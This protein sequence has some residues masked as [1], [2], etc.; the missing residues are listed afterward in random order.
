MYKNIIREI[1]AEV[2]NGKK[3]GKNSHPRIIDYVNAI[4]KYEDKNF[5]RK[6]TP[7]EVHKCQESIRR[8]VQHA[9][10]KLKEEG[11]LGKIGKHYVPIKEAHEYNSR[12]FLL[13]NLHAS[14]N[15]VLKISKK[16]CVLPLDKE[17]Y[18]QQK[19]QVNCGTL[20]D[21]VLKD[22]EP[23]IQNLLK[24][25]DTLKKEVH[26]LEEK[27]NRRKEKAK[28][29][30]E[31]IENLKMFIGYQY[32]YNIFR[33]ENTIVIMFNLSEDD[34]EHKKDEEL[35]KKID[36]LLTDIEKSKP[37]IKLKKTASQNTN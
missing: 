30:N 33:T 11:I 12:I 16:L 18:T 35:R 24:E 29:Y 10:E 22:I 1:Y 21:T 23:V 5:L 2:K 25:I 28:L 37:K 13:K 26:R 15:Y 4:I 34:I 17:A 36:K 8:S 32:C 19:Q 27:E 3:S 6:S 9:L 31:I 14:Q 7:E 20:D